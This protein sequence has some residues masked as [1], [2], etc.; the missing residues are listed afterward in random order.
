MHFLLKHAFLFNFPISVK[1]TTTVSFSYFSKLKT[2]R[3][4][5]N[6]FLSTSCPINHHWDSFFGWS[7]LLFLSTHSHD[8]YNGLTRSA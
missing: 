6:S 2:S 1:S 7:L 5:V 3:V 4:N 8:D